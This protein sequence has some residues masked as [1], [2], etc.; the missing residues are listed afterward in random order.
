MLTQNQRHL[1]AIEKKM[2]DLADEAKAIM[3]TATKEGRERSDEENAEIAER[4][5]A[6]KNLKKDAEKLEE[7]IDVDKDVLDLTKGIPVSEETEI[8][9]NTPSQEQIKSLGEQFIE[10][11]GYKQLIESGLNGEWKTGQIDLTTKA[12]VTTTPGTA[13]TPAVYQPGVVETLYQPPTV[14]DLMPSGQAGASIIRYVEEGTGGTAGAGVTNAA[15]S[16]SEGDAKPESALA[17]EEVSEPVQKIATFLPVSDEMLEDAPMI[18]SYINQ[19]LSLFIRLAEDDQLL[20][21]S[22][23]AP[24]I[25]GLLDRSINTYP[26]GTVDNNAVA[27][28]KAANNT[29]GSSFL[30]PDSIVL[31]PANWG[32][33]RLLTDQNDQFFGGGPFYGPYGGPQGPAS[34]NR[35]SADNIWGLNVVVTSAIGAGTALLGSFRQAAQVFRKGGLT[36]EA[37]NSHS[38]FFQKNL[39][40]I[41]AEERL[42]LAVYRPAAFTQI[43]GLD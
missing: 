6:I 38:D 40:A 8:R 33:T 7:Q 14:A 41:R 4:H 24:D 37:S 13:L 21:G 42:A 32:V 12:T 22:G 25:S 31:N 9:V 26:A 16:V 35:F 10:S 11:K 17:F 5:E 29:R 15:D 34:A 1:K 28:F 36:V 18:Q 20:N 39:T 43:T 19:R 30:S 3:D 27:I 23:T 2:A